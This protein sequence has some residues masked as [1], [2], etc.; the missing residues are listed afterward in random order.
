MSKLEN[1][2]SQENLLEEIE[3]S[4]NDFKKDIEKNRQYTLSKEDFQKYFE[5]DDFKQRNV[6]DCR[7]VA[8]LDSI[9]HLSNYESLV[10]SSVK[11]INENIYDI[12]LPLWDPK[13]KAYHIDINKYNQ[14]TISGNLLNVI[15]SKKW[16]KALVIATWAALLWTEEYDVN[17]LVW[18][19]SEEVFKAVI[20]WVN[21]YGE[22]SS[23]PEFY[24][25]LYSILESFDARKSCLVIS[26]NQGKWYDK[27]NPYSWSNHA[28]SVESTSEKDWELYVTISNPA[29]SS[30]TYTKS[31][32]ELSKSCHAFRYATYWNDNQYEKFSRK[33][34]ILTK[35]DMGGIAKDIVEDSKKRWDN[36][37]EASLSWIIEMSWKEDE[38]LRQNRWDVLVSELPYKSNNWKFNDLKVVSRW[39]ECT[40][41][42][43]DRNWP[44]LNE[45]WTNDVKI[46]SIFESNNEEQLRKMNYQLLNK[47]Q[48]IKDK[49]WLSMDYFK[50][51]WYTS[52]IYIKIW[53]K[54]LSL[55]KLKISPVYQ[56]MVNTQFAMYLYAPRIA[57]LINRM[58][59]DYVDTKKWDKTNKHPFFIDEHWDLVFDDDPLAFKRENNDSRRD[60]F[61][62][63][64]HNE[65]IDKCM[66]YVDAA[67]SYMAD[68]KDDTITCLKNRSALWID[69]R[70]I[71]TKQK[72]ADFLNSFCH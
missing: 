54:Y 66:N 18:W 4:L 68:F 5:W 44:T 46:P 59:H 7:L 52:N 2:P 28:V 10:R 9:T 51:M 50:N 69:S 22:K 65:F 64:Y 40:I 35:K 37:P 55:S 1:E 58:L 26:V 24:N 62:W 33:I 21:V 70:D 16:L 11:K 39:K 48:P 61:K 47:N 17:K 32:T 43:W 71:I 53:S 30:R 67:Y 36:S 34:S 14:K 42:D 31:F 57:T 3:L 25:H 6:W 13:W 29:D 49:T 15:A 27:L 72:I 19:C 60:K 8:A 45:M 38:K 56:N 23:S 63:K 12:K 20:Y 41:I